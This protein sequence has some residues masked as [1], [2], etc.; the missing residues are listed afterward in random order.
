MTFARRFRK[1]E[2]VTVHG[3]RGLFV[4]EH[5]VNQAIVRLD[6]GTILHVEHDDI[7]HAPVDVVGAR[8][9]KRL[10]TCPDC[11][12]DLSYDHDVLEVTPRKG[13]TPRRKRA[14][15]AVVCGFCEF[16]QEVTR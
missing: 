8:I 1:D 7:R 2:R 14:I 10:T 6:G 4:R 15:A 3:Q 9:V 13:A 12:H 16:I 5:G 11:G